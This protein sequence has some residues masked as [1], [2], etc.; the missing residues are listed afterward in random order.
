MDTIWGGG[1]KLQR[2]QLET[3]WPSFIL[4]P[5]LQT[6]RSFVWNIPDRFRR[7]TSASIRG[8]TRWKRV[9]CS[10]WWVLRCCR[11]VTHAHQ[12]WIYV[13]PKLLRFHDPVLVSRICADGF[14]HFQMMWLSCLQRLLFSCL[15]VAPIVSLT[16]SVFCSPPFHILFDVLAFLANILFHPRTRDTFLCS[17]L[18]LGRT[19]SCLFYV[20]CDWGVDET[21][22]ALNPLL[23]T[24][25]S[26]HVRYVETNDPNIWHKG[27]EVKTTEENK[28][29]DHCWITT[30]MCWIIMSKKQT[31]LNLCCRDEGIIQ[32]SLNI[33]TQIWTWRRNQPQQVEGGFG[34]HFVAQHT[35]SI[36]QKNAI[37][38]PT[39]GVWTID[40][41]SIKEPRKH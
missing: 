16:L 9:V 5:F 33:K 37:P 13:V 28:H 18:S 21:F 39:G 27:R 7:R 34:Q 11:P 31:C 19:K 30:L 3:A 20:M 32:T 26:K 15:L 29:N 4:V 14:E 38:A 41:P 24:G 25:P 35:K 1:S 12:C 36:T 8:V 6:R 2:K 40:S 17:I 23:N 22:T 10:S